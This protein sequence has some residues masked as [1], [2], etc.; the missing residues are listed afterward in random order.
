VVTVPTENF[1]DIFWKLCHEVA[2]FN[3]DSFVSFY[4]SFVGGGNIAALD[5]GP[6]VF[7]GG[8]GLGLSVVVGAP[9]SPPS[10]FTYLAAVVPGLL[11]YGKALTTLSKV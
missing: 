11:G 1:F 10:F 5:K 6:V 8:G 9:P 2:C 7:G 4:G 3:A